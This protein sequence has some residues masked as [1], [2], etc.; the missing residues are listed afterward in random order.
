MTFGIYEASDKLDNVPARIRNSFV[1]R[2]PAN[3]YSQ[4]FFYK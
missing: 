3:L 2:S 1:E 4:S